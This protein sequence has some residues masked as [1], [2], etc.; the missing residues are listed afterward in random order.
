M[1]YLFLDPH[2][3]RRL[4][5][6]EF[7]ERLRIGIEREKAKSRRFAALA[8][9]LMRAQGAKINS[10]EMLLGHFMPP[11]PK[12]R[13]PAERDREIQRMLKIAEATDA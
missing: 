7:Y 8:F 6:G 1:D 5:V 11:I 10:P 4:T 13:T 9:L 2:E 12:Y 3:F